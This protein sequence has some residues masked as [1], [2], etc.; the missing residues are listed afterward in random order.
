MDA[1]FF[2]KLRTDF[3]RFYY[4]EGVKPFHFQ[5]YL[6][7]KDLPP[8]D[9]PPYDESGEPPYLEQW[10]DAE[11][12]RQILG[13]SCISLL[14]DTLKLYFEALQRRVIRFQFTD[15]EKGWFRNGFVAAY[16]AA[17]G[18]ILD[19]DWSDCPVD[20]DVI[21][22]IVLARNRGQHGTDLWTL[23]V[24]HDGRT[25]S[26]HPRPFFTSEREM[27]TWASRDWHEGSLWTP[28]LE[29]TRSQLMV[30]IHEVEKLVDWIE[31]RMGQAAE[32]QQ[33]PSG[34]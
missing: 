34:E 9:D 25:M 13:L 6:I 30:A 1:N 23:H 3:I 5:Q 7:E 29:I 4:D 26:K 10:L 19:T 11:T 28:N 16:K 27:E 8:F 2:L 15:D 24:A 21:E 32:W 33:R 18:E 12:A 31:G 17:L 20:F 14:S 22:Q